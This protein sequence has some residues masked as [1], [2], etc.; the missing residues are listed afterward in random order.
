M[1]HQP[2]KLMWV[3]AHSVIPGNEA[4]DYKGQGRVTVGCMINKPNIATLTGIR[5]AYVSH[6]G[7]PQTAGWAERQCGFC[8]RLDYIAA[9]SNTR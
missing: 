6:H 8:P 1:G 3:K 5:Q 7:A 9:P 2:R 4:A